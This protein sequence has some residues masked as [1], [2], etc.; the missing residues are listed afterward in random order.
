MSQKRYGLRSQD[1]DCRL[2]T[3]KQRWS[4]VCHSVVRWVH[5]TCTRHQNVRMCWI[6]CCDV[7]ATVQIIMSDV[8]P[9]VIRASCV[10]S[11]P[12]SVIWSCGDPAAVINPVGSNTTRVKFTRYLAFCQVWG[13]SVSS[14]NDCEFTSNVWNPFGRAVGLSCSC[15]CTTNI[16]QT[17]LQN[18]GVRLRL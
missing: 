17:R 15:C 13:T 16:M 5:C 8:L 9:Q 7:A 10:V 12:V 14:S 3:M 18:C 11:A 6:T 1:V 4:A 2:K